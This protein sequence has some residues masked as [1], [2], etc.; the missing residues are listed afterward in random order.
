MDAVIPAL[1]AGLEAR[2]HP[3]ELVDRRLGSVQA[4]RIDANGTPLGIPQPDALTPHD[5][6]GRSVKC[7]DV[8][9]H[10]PGT[11]FGTLAILL[12]PQL[13][14][15][16]IVGHVVDDEDPSTRGHPDARQPMWLRI[17][18]ISSRGLNGLAT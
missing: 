2:G 16:D 11:A 4:I 14:D 10:Q 12:P 9:P 17:F 5:M 15:L 18:C 6:N 3:C 7:R 13:G 8:R 1:A